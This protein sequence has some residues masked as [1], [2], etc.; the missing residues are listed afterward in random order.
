MP[1]NTAKNIY[2]AGILA[3]A[4]AFSSF[5]FAYSG[6]E[7]EGC[8]N[9][10]VVTAVEAVGGGSGMGAAAGALAGGAI[11]NQAGDAAG[12][13]M[14]GTVLGAVTGAVGGHYTEKAVRGSNGWKVSV[15][16]DNGNTRIVSMKKQPK[17]KIGDK[18]SVEGNEVVSMDSEDEGEN[19]GEQD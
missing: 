12:S 14:I 15:R 18:V 19:E 11:G 16:M 5:S 4:M 2:M 9:C 10:G 17:V 7:E 8:E 6:D 1:S 3:T 13:S